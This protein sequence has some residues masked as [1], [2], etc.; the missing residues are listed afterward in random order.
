MYTALSSMRYY[1]AD[2][3]ESHYSAL[4]PIY[5]MTMTTMV[6]DNNDHDTASTQ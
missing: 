4:C 2:E 5:D 1:S 6:H 3:K